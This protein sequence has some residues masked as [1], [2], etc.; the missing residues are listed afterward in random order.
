MKNGWARVIT[1][2]FIFTLLGSTS[3]PFMFLDYFVPKSR[4]LYYRIFYPTAFGQTTV[5]LQEG[6]RIEIKLED[7]VS[8]QTSTVGQIVNFSVVRDIVV[9]GKVVIPA[10]NPVYGEVTG[11]VKKGSVGKAGSISMTVNYTKAVDGQNVSLRSTMTKTGE[12]KL[13]TSV[14]LSVVLCPLFLLKKGQESVYEPGTRFEVFVDRN[15][16]IKAQ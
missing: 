12:E 15:V 7:E 1:I 8:S 5:I 13:G 3:A 2:L 9:D 11:V 4:I 6:T 14:A 16:E 10:G